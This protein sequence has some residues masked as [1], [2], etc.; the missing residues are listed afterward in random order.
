MNGCVVRIAYWYMISEYTV[1][2]VAAESPF[3]LEL[4]REWMRS[5]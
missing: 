3:A 2:Q 1:A 4:A 5:R